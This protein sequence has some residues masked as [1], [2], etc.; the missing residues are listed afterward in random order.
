MAAWDLLG[1]Y[2]QMPL[3][4]LLGGDKECIRTGVTIGIL[5]EAETVG[6]ARRWVKEGF[7][8]LK[9]KG[10]RDA[11]DDVSRVR[12]VREAVGPDVD[13]AFDAN[14]GYTAAGAL[15]LLRGC[16]GVGLAFLEQPTPRR[17]FAALGE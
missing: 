2:A 11:T 6:Q 14:Q 7:R 1:R 8:F 9:L 16:A 3:W 15:E 13:L 5:P 12:K 4:K 10:G 17:D